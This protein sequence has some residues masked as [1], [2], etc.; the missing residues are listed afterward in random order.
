LLDIPGRK[1]A[2]G[3]CPKAIGTFNDSHLGGSG[4]RLGL[5]TTLGKSA[6][7]VLALVTELVK[8]QDAA[9]PPKN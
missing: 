6:K 8:I 2:V 5:A 3:W 4:E 9:H 7:E 1:K